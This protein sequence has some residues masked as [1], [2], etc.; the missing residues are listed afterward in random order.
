[1]IP[2][3]RGFQYIKRKSRNSLNHTLMP[4]KAFSTSTAGA[5]V[6]QP[7]MQQWIGAIWQCGNRAMNKKKLFLRSTF[8]YS[9]ISCHFCPSLQHKRR[10][11]SQA[12]FAMVL[13]RKSRGVWICAVSIF[14]VQMNNGV[15]GR[16][17]DYND[18]NKVQRSSPNYDQFC[19]FIGSK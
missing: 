15:P 10:R 2:N 6:R 11:S 12:Q 5:K 1:M 9:N 16:S 7:A 4:Y 18:Y 13:P 19:N 8:F 17:H 3:I 14:M